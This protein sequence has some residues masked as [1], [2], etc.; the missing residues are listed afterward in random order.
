MRTMCTGNG[1][2]ILVENIS[3]MDPEFF[4][5]RGGGGGRLIRP[6]KLTSKNIIKTN[7]Q[8]TKRH[9]YRGGG[10]KYYDML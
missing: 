1:V 4:R 6:I 2:W 3:F 5:G 10:L 9:E 7:K 8:K